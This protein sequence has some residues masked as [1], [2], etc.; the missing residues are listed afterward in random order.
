M[1]KRIGFIGLGLMGHGMASNLLAKGHP[2]TLLGTHARANVADL[3]GRGASAVGTPAEVAAASEVVIT[4]VRSSADVEGLVYGE[5]GILAGARPGLVHIDTT[6]AN[7]VSTARIAADYA[8]RGLRFADA[9]L[10]RTPREAAEGRLNVMLGADTALKDEILPV[11]RGFAENVFHV[12][13]VGAGHTMK[14]INNFMA[15]SHA[16]VAAEAVAAAR[17]AGLDLKVMTDIISAGGANSAQFQM[18]MPW[19]VD[20]DPSRLQFTIANARKDLAYYGAFASE[21][22]LSGGVAPAVLQTLTLAA[23]LGRGDQFVPRL[24][25]MLSDLAGAGEEGTAPR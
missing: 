2:L 15:M 7:P 25:D 19:V 5:D 9:P 22:R 13:P 8:A 18:I 1:T 11:L 6:T 4:C 10:G 21:N 12:G 24:A 14:L 20:R 3:V 17:A 16:C 23:A